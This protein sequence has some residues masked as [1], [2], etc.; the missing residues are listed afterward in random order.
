[1]VQEISARIVYYSIVLTNFNHAHSAVQHGDTQVPVR[2]FVVAFL[3]AQLA[4]ER[5][6]VHDFT[7]GNDAPA[8]AQETCAR[9]LPD[10]GI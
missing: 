4:D 7:I 9:A 5:R 10:A 8:I 1:M 2:L 6:P 3:D